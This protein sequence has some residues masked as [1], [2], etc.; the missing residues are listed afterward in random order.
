MEALAQDLRY[1]RSF[2]AKAP[3]NFGDGEPFKVGVPPSTVTLMVRR[4]PDDFAP[5]A[6]GVIVDIRPIKSG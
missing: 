6:D 5:Y 2:S 3:P 4:V 1:T